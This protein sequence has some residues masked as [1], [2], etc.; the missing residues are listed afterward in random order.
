MFQRFSCFA[1]VLGQGNSLNKGNF[2]IGDYVCAVYQTKW[3]IGE[4]VSIDSP[5]KEAEISFL[6]KK[7]QLLQW[8]SREDIV[9]I[10]F[11]DIICQVMKPVPTGKCQRMFRLVPGDKEK[12]ERAFN[13]WN[14]NA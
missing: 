13:A 14:S 9:W 12:I 4:V 11:Q 1:G 8:P 2:D 10:N 6:E 7:K 3:Y 5:E